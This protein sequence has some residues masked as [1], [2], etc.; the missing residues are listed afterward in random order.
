MPGTSFCVAGRM[1]SLALALEVRSVMQSRS[2][3]AWRINGDSSDAF[4]VWRCAGAAQGIER[5]RALLAERGTQ[6]QVALR[7]GNLDG[8]LLQRVVQRPVIGCLHPRRS[9][10]GFRIQPDHQRKVEAGVTEAGQPD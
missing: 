9:A 8:V 6:A 4:R 3:C 1:V 7:E 2:G 5:L 10:R